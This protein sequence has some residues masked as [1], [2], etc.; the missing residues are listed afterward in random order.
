MLARRAQERSWYNVFILQPVAVPRQQRVMLPA[1][2]GVMS[3]DRCVK[4]GPVMSYSQQPVEMVELM[5]T[6]GL[7]QAEII[8]GRL[9]SAGVPVWIWQEGAGRAQ[10]LIV[11]S[12]GAGRI[13]VPSS[14]VHEAAELLMEAPDSF[15]AAEAADQLPPEGASE[16]SLFAKGIL[17]VLALGQNHLAT[18]AVLIWAVL[19]QLLDREPAKIVDCPLCGHVVEL[20]D[21]ELASGT[22]DCPYCDSRVAAAVISGTFAVL[23]HGLDRGPTLVMWQ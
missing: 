10:G 20:T 11:G 15:A 14:R 5:Q 8:A 4:G 3:T 23:L 6:F 7:L 9:R 12:L 16:I 1:A 2:T 13:M 17:L 19:Q 22:Y 21:R 18:L